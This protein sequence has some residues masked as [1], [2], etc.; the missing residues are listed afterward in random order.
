MKDERKNWSAG[1]DRPY[2]QSTNGTL[3]RQRGYILKHT[4]DFNPGDLEAEERQTGRSHWK[5]QG[6]RKG[7]FIMIYSAAK[8]HHLP[9]HWRVKMLSSQRL[10]VHPGR[11]TGA[12]TEV[13]NNSN[14]HSTTEHRLCD[15][16]VWVQIPTRLCDW[17][18]D[19]TVFVPMTSSTKWAV[20]SLAVS[21]LVLTNSVSRHDN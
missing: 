1:T 9:R 4:R 13:D 7:G 2:F 3:N 15:V 19:F 17:T 14:H 21:S 20:I 11:W 10:K 12:T 16:N 8:T 6:G 5:P 18:R